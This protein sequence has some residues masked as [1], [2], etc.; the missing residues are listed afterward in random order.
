MM[1][2]FA[3]HHQE[4]EVNLKEKVAKVNLVTV[5]FPLLLAWWLLPGDGPANG[6][7][8]LDKKRM[9]WPSESNILINNVRQADNQQLTRRF[10]II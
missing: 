5:Q 2:A 7:I 10:I 1:D 4:D 6:A 9:M 3:L 8:A